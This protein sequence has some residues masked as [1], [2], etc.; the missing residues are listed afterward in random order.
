[1]EG[2]VSP[3]YCFARLFLAHCALLRGSACVAIRVSGVWVE[4]PALGRRVFYHY[5]FFFFFRV[6]DTFCA[7]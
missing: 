6:A 4:T 7:H 3:P 2:G 1:M 5:A